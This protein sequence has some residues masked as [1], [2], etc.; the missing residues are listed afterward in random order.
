MT[1]KVKVFL[2]LG[3]LLV[4]SLSVI[5]YGIYGSQLINK[6]SNK[7]EQQTFP[8]MENSI[9]LSAIVKETKSIVTD[10]YIEEDEFYLDEL[11]HVRKAFH[12]VVASNSV[13]DLELE[14]IADL[15]DRYVERS[16][17]YLQNYL[18]KGEKKYDVV[19]ADLEEVHQIAR[20]LAEE[21]L[22]YKKNR[23]RELF[24]SMQDIRA[25][26]KRF[27]FVLVISGAIL[28][29][30][31]GFLILT[32]SRLIRN[33]GEVVV[34]ANKLAEGGLEE[35]I[36]Y[37]GND[38]VAVLR[39][40]F[41]VM[42]LSLKDMIENLDNKVNQRTFELNET[43]KEVSDILDSVKEGIF[44]FSED[45]VVYNEHSIIAEQHYNQA[46]F[47]GIE[48]KE[49]LKMDESNYLGF[50]SW[51]GMCFGNRSVLKCWDKYQRLC[52][53]QE[54]KLS[55]E[56][57]EQIIGINFQP[58]IESGKLIRI[59]VLSRDI[60]AHRDAENALLESHREQH[61]IVERVTGLVTNDV[62]DLRDVFEASKRLLAV[63]ELIHT[64][65]D[66]KSQGSFL[67]R[68][69]H[70]L[71]GHWGTLGFDE[72]SRCLG[73][74]EHLLS[75]LRDN[76][77]VEFDAWCRCFEIV[78][79][80]F[81]GLSELKNK[82]YGQDQSQMISID[83]DRY[84]KLIHEVRSKKVLS[85]AMILKS[86][87]ELNALPIK[88]YLKKYQKYI[89][90]SQSGLDKE[91][92]ILDIK[93]NDALVQREVFLN[94]DDVILHLIRNAVDHGIENTKTRQNLG[95]GPGHISIAYQL[96]NNYHNII[97]SDDG[98]G[99][100]PECVSKKAL[101]LG[102]VDQETLTGLSL[103]QR[104]ELIFKAGFSK[105]NEVSMLSGRGVGMDVVKN[106]LEELD[107]FV[108]LKSELGRG[109]EF[110]LRYPV[111]PL[112]EL[113]NNGIHSR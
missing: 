101:Q 23:S 2:F 72:I 37:S 75:Q 8:I 29:L 12:L 84:Q 21:I 104:K 70:T 90:R 9:K 43:K 39:R 63:V 3:M 91:I 60:T 41:E 109:T 11:P 56:G 49:L 68:E 102:L 36:S 27:T 73:D 44:T 93:N 86:L 106:R 96:K 54:L 110:I 24:L 6:S 112:G 35:S 105:K 65:V 31:I 34:H 99:V 10:A 67:F 74:A 111:Q 45:M 51:V 20:Q 81:I 22:D 77:Y 97:V 89:E 26:A 17:N 46:E 5:S 25:Q 14:G 62:E 108:E 61:L 42:R 30:V 107:G 88:T 32:L 69:V 92:A 28:L 16:E 53:I 83:K 48:V 85:Q 64:T 76:V 78:C 18:I 71:K 1:I 100:D 15:Y 4:S 80:E 98:A 52:P 57:Q 66:L 95:K 38:E 94:L 59:M 82:I 87:H 19:D 103:Q 13:M 113:S 50:K 79:S 40:S 33:I 7:I 58:I 55:I 47:K